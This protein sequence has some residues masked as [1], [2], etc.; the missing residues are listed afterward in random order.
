MPVTLVARHKRPKAP[1]GA[2][3][4]QRFS[5]ASY[6]W[7]P[8]RPSSS[9]YAVPAR[10]SNPQCPS[11]L[12][13][14]LTWPKIRVWRPGQVPILPYTIMEAS[15]T[16]LTPRPGHPLQPGQ[17]DPPQAESVYADS[18]GPLFS[19]YL[20]LAGEED[21]KMTENWKGDAD[22]IL[23]FVSRHSTRTTVPQRRL[24][25]RPKT[26]LFSAA[27]AAFVAVS[28]Q[29]LKPSSQDISAFYLANIYQILNGSQVVIP[30]TLPDPSIPF[31]PP[32]SAVWV[33]SLWV[34]SLLISLTCALLATLL[35]QWARRYT[36]I[37][38]TRYSPHKRSRIRAFFAE[39]VEK[40][41]LPWA[42]EALPA[43][44]PSLFPSSS[45]ASLC[46]LSVSTIRFSRWPYRGSG[47]V[48]VCTCA[49]H[50]CRCFGMIVHTTPR[51]L[52]RHGTFTLE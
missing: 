24:T 10:Y 45:R 18:S 32:T 12:T 30:P 3:D 25:P 1:V 50:S 37:T 40:L 38:R 35:Q 27:V 31:S 14:R 23:I 8:P 52:H 49:L 16:S 6:Y 19:M 39:G 44:L 5:G 33:N 26:G 4:H 46:S 34:L 20:K 17:Q 22:G 15:L 9:P 42:V 51:F 2:L 47:F 43:L 36:K 11:L 48:R 13:K 29:D 7:E 28:V 41:H 21:V